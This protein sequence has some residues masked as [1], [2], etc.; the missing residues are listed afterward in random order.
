VIIA[1]T[2]PREKFATEPKITLDG[3]QASHRAA[4]GVLEQHH[5]GA[6]TK[7]RSSKYSNNLIEQDH[8][9]TK[10]RLG[11]MLGLKRFRTASIAIAGVE[12]Q[13]RSVQS[14]KASHQ[15]EPG[16]RNLECSSLRNFAHISAASCASSEICTAAD[17]R[18]FVDYS[19]CR[20]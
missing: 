13:E 3:Y 4:R 6:R 19:S 17:E 9:S 11:S 7:I 20:R 10:L 18:I 5:D 8:R 16:A 14:G 1:S 12:D 2:D 15:S